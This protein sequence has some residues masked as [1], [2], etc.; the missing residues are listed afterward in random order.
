MTT[1]A[2][3]TREHREAAAAAWDHLW[4]DYPSVTSYVETGKAGMLPIRRV[5]QAIADAEARGEQRGRAAERQSI[6]AWM[7]S[8]IERG[9][10]VPPGTPAADDPDR[11]A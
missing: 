11:T 5:A 8:S 1:P 9:D 10:H 6:V 7:R 2:K 4:R 3:I